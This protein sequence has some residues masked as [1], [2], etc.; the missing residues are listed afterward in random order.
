MNFAGGGGRFG[1]GTGNDYSQPAVQKQS[2]Y[3]SSGI[4]IG[5]LGGQPS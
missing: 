4:S 1:G 3:G 2:S 5:A